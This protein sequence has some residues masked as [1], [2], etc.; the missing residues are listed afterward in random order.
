MTVF[1]LVFCTCISLLHQICILCPLCLNLK[2]NVMAGSF[3]LKPVLCFD[4]RLNPGGFWMSDSGGSSKP[5][6]YPCRSLLKHLKSKLISSYLLFH[7]ILLCLLYD[8]THRWNV[9]NWRPKHRNTRQELHSCRHD[10]PA[11]GMR[12]PKSH[13]RA[14]RWDIELT[15]PKL[16]LWNSEGFM[17]V[18]F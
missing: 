15:F 5:F 9:A 4:L 8:S 14:T 10:P 13:F 11:A 6:I 18:C 17:S 3:H 12:A 2:V 1:L 7:T 16:V